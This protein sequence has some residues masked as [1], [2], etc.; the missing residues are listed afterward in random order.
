MKRIFVYGSM[1]RG[2]FN[3]WRLKNSEFIDTCQISGYTIYDTKCDYPVAIKDDTKF[4]RG[5]RFSINENIWLDLLR[6][7]IGSGYS[8]EWNRTIQAYIF[9]V[10]SLEK[11][12][13]RWGNDIEEVGEEWIK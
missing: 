9:Y 13:N 12:K 10:F 11:A 4:I 7:E 1:K 2:F 5:E 6:I 3:N 8:V